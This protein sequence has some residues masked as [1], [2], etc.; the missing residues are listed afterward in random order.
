MSLKPP[1]DRLPPAEPPRPHR[2][3]SRREQA[4]HLPVTT[5][6]P[7]FA[8]EAP[9]P[10]PRPTPSR[11]RLLPPGFFSALLTGALFAL[12]LVLVALA[13]PPF[14]LFDVAGLVEQQPDDESA[15]DSTAQV[16]FTLTAA[17]PQLEYE[18]LALSAE[19]EALVV[20]LEIGLVVLSPADYL[21][22]EFP[23]SG[24]HCPADLPPDHALASAVY[25]LARGGAVPDRLTL[26]V[27]PLSEATQGVALE[28][29]LGNDSTGSWEYLPATTNEAG[30]VEVTLSYVPRCLALLRATGEAR[31]LSLVLGLQDVLSQEILTANPT[32]VPGRLRPTRTGALDVVLAPGYRTGQGY[33]VMPHAQNYTDPAIVDLATVQTLLENPAL[34]AEHARQLAAF[35][36]AD[37]GHAGLV[38]DYR[39]I[40]F[41][42]RD[43]YTAFVRELAGLLKRGGQALTVI[44][45]MPVSA[46]E[47]IWET[48][49]YDLT[50][51]GQ[52]ADTL[53]LL[54]PPDPAA[55]APGGAVEQALA[56]AVT[57]VSRGTLALGVSASSVAETP[58]GTL[59]PVDFG[60]ALAHIGEV[61]LDPVDQVAPGQTVV[62]RLTQPAGIRA[63]W[64]V[65]EPEQ[66]PFI[67]YYDAAGALLRTMWITDAYALHARL[68]LAADHRLG[69]V[70]VTDLLS[71]DATPGLAA[72]LLAYRLDRPLEAS[73]LTLEWR[74]RSGETVVAQA[75]A[76]PDQPFT[77][78][79]WERPGP[80]TVGLWAGNTLL[81]ETTITVIVAE[82]TPTPTVTPAPSTPTATMPPA[83]P[84]A[85]A[86]T[87]TPAAALPDLSALPTADPA[88]LTVDLGTAFEVG[89]HVGSLSRTLLQ[90]GRMSMKWIA[91][92]VR[93]RVGAM[94][95]AQ[96]DPIVQ[97]QG[98]GFKVLLSVSGDPDEFTALDRAEYLSLF[99]TYMSG[100]A[101]YSPDAIEIWPEANA[102]MSPADYLRL[103]ALSYSAI[104]T[105]NPH[106]LVISGALRPSD[107][108]AAP[109]YN[110]A[111]FAQQ[112]AALGALQVADCA[113][114]HYTLG[115][116]SPVSL[117]GDPRGDSP[118][119]YLPRVIE[120]ARE[121]FGDAEPLC[122]TR[123]GYLS[124]EGMPALPADY[125]WAQNTSAGQQARWL[126]DAVGLGMGNP[127][128]RLMIL[129]SLDS[130]AF[131][132]GSPE[133][134]YALIRPDG[135][136]PA[137][138]A[139][140][141]LLKEE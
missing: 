83:T 44:V 58:D 14:S 65:S 29:H 43:A 28:L 22:G 63:E 15:S 97:G 16:R 89:V 36:L 74:V 17:S 122:F 93:Y 72:A 27:M 124:A 91:L 114:V 98:N 47:G 10:T 133:A 59:L 141:P 54:G 71:R 32:I 137:C 92:D 39:A 104:K 64:G 67:R 20:P 34:R 113:G 51:L 95:G 110:D 128:I 120:R 105:V 76:V 5:V 136:C 87:E 116:V 1:A 68:R 3:E 46:G 134:G 81:S 23:T 8:D 26:R 121:A 90:V 94:P 73:P 129:W 99:T 82:P 111:A 49:G 31:R 85:P 52:L 109:N 38:L 66:T 6:R 112:L 19:K 100:L 117:E 70:F 11:R 7:Q 35:A 45:P 107:D 24:W 75:E 119:Y 88:W 126:M 125:A 139:L 79:A 62:A 78:T 33:A 42:L 103:L 61:T 56:W 131:A 37:S 18:G 21:A 12:P 50:A 48:G 108:P 57:Q 135:S 96:Q 84:I 123:L 106:I 53:V 140:A 2:R 55:Y 115:A 130:S 25:S 9:V 30:A 4:R 86:P 132:E 118:I 77:F 127:Q 40:P 102:L 41:G 13:L 138:E 60:E 101:A 80:L 69:G